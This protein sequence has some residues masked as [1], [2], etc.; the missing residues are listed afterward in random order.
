MSRLPSLD[1]SVGSRSCLGAVEKKE[2]KETT[3]IWLILGP[4]DHLIKCAANAIY[5]ISRR[6]PFC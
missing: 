1:D 5:S 3:P 2:K 6:L 4:S